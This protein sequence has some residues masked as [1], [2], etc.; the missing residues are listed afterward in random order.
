[1]LAFEFQEYGFQNVPFLLSFFVSMLHG[2]S[3]ISRPVLDEQPGPPL[4]HIMTSSA[5][6]GQW[7]EHQNVCAAR[8]GVRITPALEVIKEQM[9]RAL[10]DVQVSRVDAVQMISDIH[11]S[12]SAFTHLTVGSQKSDFF[13]RTWWPG[14]RSCVS[15]VK[16][17]IP[18]RLARLW[19]PVADVPLAKDAVTPG[20]GR[21][22]SSTKPVVKGRCWASTSGS[23][24]SVLARRTRTN[25][26][27]RSRERRAV[28][29]FGS[30]W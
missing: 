17:S 5:R 24:R 6:R 10:V 20:R 13:I 21:A 14:W 19:R 1:M 9:L 16:P 22:K 25:I 27:A 18:C 28:R 29:K 8:T 11:A 3:S 30:V 26:S 15:V 7:L 12:E 2:P 23:A 4:I